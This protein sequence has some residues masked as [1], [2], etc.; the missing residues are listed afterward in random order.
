[1]STNGNSDLN[2]NSSN[3]SDIN[4]H[5]L[6]SLCLSFAVS[7]PLNAWRR[8][9]SWNVCLF[10]CSGER[11]P[12]IDLFR[13]CVAAIPRLLPDGMGQHEL[14]SLLTRLTVHMDDELGR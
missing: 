7:L 5:Q 9:L 3:E 2:L 8:S 10:L 4:L 1:M 6:F 14:I 13:I 11:K 12:K